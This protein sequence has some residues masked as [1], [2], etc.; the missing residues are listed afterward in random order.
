MSVNILIFPGKIWVIGGI[1]KF[2]EREPR[3]KGK[4]G[5]LGFVAEEAV[6]GT[7]RSLSLGG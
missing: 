1:I 6:E 2:G 4:G 5:A 3:G 7:G